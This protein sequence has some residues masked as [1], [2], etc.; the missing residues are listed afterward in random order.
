MEHDYFDGIIIVAT[1][2]KFNEMCKRQKLTRIASAY[3]HTRSYLDSSIWKQE[4]P[5]TQWEIVNVE[6][7]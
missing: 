1:K 5:G 7:Q 4:K 6:V 3:P 2:L